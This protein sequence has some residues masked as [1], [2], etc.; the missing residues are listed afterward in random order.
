MPLHCY[1]LVFDLAG[2][3]VSIEFKPDRLSVTTLESRMDFPEIRCWRCEA[4]LQPDHH[5]VLKPGDFGT[6]YY[7][8]NQ[9]WPR[10]IGFKGN[11]SVCCL[12]YHT[13]AYTRLM[14]HEHKDLEDDPEEARRIS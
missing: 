5:H 13:G 1:T 6:D 12:C 9:G 3:F 11:F 8:E 2:G 4:F 7:F 10:T 14:W